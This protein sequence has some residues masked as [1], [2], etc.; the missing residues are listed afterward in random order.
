[1]SIS[2]LLI[3]ILFLTTLIALFKDFK[4][5]RKKKNYFFISLL[6]FAIIAFALS[7]VKECDSELKMDDE[8]NKVVKRDSVI[9]IMNDKIDSL[10]TKTKIQEAIINR[11]DEMA[12]ETRLI[13][14]KTDLIGK[15]QDTLRL[16]TNIISEEHSRI[17]SLIIRFSL[18]VEIE[19]SKK[20]GRGK[21]NLLSGPLRISLEDSKS[22][23]YYFSTD[24]NE[25]EYY[26]AH[27][28]YY[29]S[30]NEEGKLV[31]QKIENLKNI[32][33]LN[34]HFSNYL[35]EKNSR[36][37]KFVFEIVINGLILFQS[38]ILNIDTERLGSPYESFIVVSDIFENVDKL[39]SN[40]LNR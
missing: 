21:Q 16:K 30:L 25:Y 33:K 39:Y 24:T 36:N 5:K 15:T 22:K 31:G 37:G 35:Q 18:E 34:I 6:V 19:S 4:G 9:N 11:L 12:R 10:V 40:A 27:K 29:L 20:S 8:V 38:P 3:I 2:H 23:L 17:S 32:I 28:K 13:S 14:S 1:M 26:G 7:I